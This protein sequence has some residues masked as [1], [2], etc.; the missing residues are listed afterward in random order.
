MGNNLTPQWLLWAREIQALAQTSRFYAPD[1]FQRQRYARL[2]EIAAEI[3]STYANL[4]QE[5]VLQAYKAQDG[6]ATP[7]V[8]VRAAIFQ[9]GKLL[10]G[11]ERDDGGWTLP[12]GWADVEDTPSA[13]VEREVWEETG[14][15]AKAIRIIGV[16]DSNCSPYPAV[17]QLYRVMFLCE[18]SGG[19]AR[20]S[21]ETSEVCFFEQTEIPAELS[22]SRM[23]KRY[24]DAA[25]A[26][27]ADPQR[28]ADFD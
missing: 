24:I 26:A 12:G 10:L 22:A 14:F 2:T 11:R 5:A 23:E 25:F 16:Y 19:E 18:I 20:P 8:G 4:P 13:A 27:Y 3:V 7:K 21:D 17:F 9:D 28:P 1:E 15:T 6:Y